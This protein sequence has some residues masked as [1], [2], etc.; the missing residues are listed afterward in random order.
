MGHI[1]Y[2][3]NP[4]Q[5]RWLRAMRPGRRLFWRSGVGTGKTNTTIFTGQRLAHLNPGHSGLICSH[6]LNHCYLEI[7]R[8]LILMLQQAGTYRSV[9]KIERVVRLNNGSSIQWAGAHKPDSLDGRNVAWALGDEVR[10]W[11]EASYDK[12]MSR[13][14]VDAPYPFEGL[15]TTPELN[16]IARRFRDNPDFAEIVAR[17]D[18]N[19]TN[20]QAD[21]YDRLKRSLP[22]EL[23]ESYVNGEWMHMGG[24]VFPEYSEE[25]HTSNPDLYD[26]FYPV[27]IALDPAADKSAA[28]FFQHYPWCRTH[29]AKDCIH[30]LDELMLDDVPTLWMPDRWERM[31]Y[32]RNWRSLGTVYIDVAGRHRSEATHLSSVSVLEGR[33]FACKWTTD[34]VKRSVSSGITAMRGKLKPYDGPPSLYFHPRLLDDPTERGIVRSIQ[35][36]RRHESK[37]KP[38]DGQPIKDGKYDHV[39]DALRYAVVNLCPMPA[40][41]IVRPVEQ[42]PRRR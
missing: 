40:V 17:T 31:K 16:W 9:N 35:E 22:P 37:G 21:Y 29:G 23:Y 33:G 15:F 18:E 14:R 28:L 11:P 10:Y 30:V 27:D 42:L 2:T 8:P 5:E 13:I 20:L 19:A 41:S 26:S 34:P 4:A 12:F 1:P 25:I 32:E 38:Q 7:I 39:R 6:N 36:S 24:G 3:P